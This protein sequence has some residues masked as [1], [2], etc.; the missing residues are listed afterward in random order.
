MAYKSYFLLSD[1]DIDN[2]ATHILGQEIVGYELRRLK[3]KMR[4]SKRRGVI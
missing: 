4:K 2:Q 1:I 3:K